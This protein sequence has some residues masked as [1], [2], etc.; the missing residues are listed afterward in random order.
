MCLVYN[1]RGQQFICRHQIQNRISSFAF[2]VV[3]NAL[4]GPKSSC[5]L[6]NDRKQT[7]ADTLFLKVEQTQFDEWLKF[8]CSCKMFKR[9]LFLSASK[10][11]FVLSEEHFSEKTVN[12]INLNVSSYCFYLELIYDFK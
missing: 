9:Y 5:L 2:Q 10:P 7:T 12:E 4:S 11:T 3:R 1:I 6:Q 8:V